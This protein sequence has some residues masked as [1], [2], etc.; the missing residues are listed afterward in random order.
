MTSRPPLTSAPRTGSLPAL[1]KVPPR[2][3]GFALFG[4]LALGPLAAAEVT[5]ALDAAATALEQLRAANVARSELARESAAWVNERERLQA[6]IA[7]TR[8][9]LARLERDATTAE[10]QRDQARTRLAAIGDTSDLETVRRHMGEAGARLRTGLSIV[11]RSVPPGT[12]ATPAGELAGEAAF[13]AATRALEAAERAAG[14][15]SVE[16]VTGQR[17]GQT[18]AVKLL[19]VAGAIAWWVA[20]DGKAAGT[21]R[22]V[23]G[24]L[25]LDPATDEAARSTI[26]NALAQAEGRAQPTVLLMPTPIGGQP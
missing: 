1:C 2:W 25:H 23:D 19:R 3:V 8:A 11:A 26:T 10:T 16:V 22:M 9:E 5:P 12:V 20:L 21:T 4:M 13:D 18:E 6:A 7:A 14:T 15:L 17:A 24:T